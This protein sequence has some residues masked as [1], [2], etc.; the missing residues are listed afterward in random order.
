VNVLLTP[1]SPHPSELER[2]GVARVT[3][4]SGLAALAYGEAVRVAGAALAPS[5]G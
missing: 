2:L 1:A 4:G 3:Q 5:G